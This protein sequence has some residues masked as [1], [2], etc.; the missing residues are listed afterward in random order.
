MEYWRNPTRKDRV[1][2]VTSHGE[3][4]SMRSLVGLG[5]LGAIGILVAAI[6]ARRETRDVLRESGLKAL[7]Y[8]NQQAENLRETG[9]VIVQQ[10]KRLLACKLS[11]PVSRFTDAD[12]QAYREEK[13]EHLGG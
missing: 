7:D 12:T 2:S 9:D 10:A 4:K 5:L 11:A 3:F 13:L 6:L 8:L 1:K